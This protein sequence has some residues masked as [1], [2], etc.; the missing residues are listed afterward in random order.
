MELGRM[1]K[2]SWVKSKVIGGGICRLIFEFDKGGQTTSE[3]VPRKRREITPRLED[4]G[5]LG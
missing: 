1:K 4:Q 5:T 2:Q 3:G